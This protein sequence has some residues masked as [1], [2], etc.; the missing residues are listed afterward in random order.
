MTATGCGRG[1]R[2]AAAA[3]SAAMARQR[4]DLA[5]TRLTG[6]LKH[7]GQSKRGELSKVA[8]KLSLRLLEAMLAQRTERLANLA[9]RGS[10]PAVRAVER[11]RGAFSTVAAKLLDPG[12]AK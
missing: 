5:S 1:G 11:R 10:V 6:E 3:R 4:L 2:S 9:R 7:L 8:P 12:T